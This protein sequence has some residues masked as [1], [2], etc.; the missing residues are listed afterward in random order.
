MILKIKKMLFKVLSPYLYYYYKAKIRFNKFSVSVMSVDDTI[1]KMKEGYSIVRFGDGEFLIIAG[2]DRKN[3]QDYSFELASGIA[4]AVKAIN[5][6]KYLVCLPETLSTIDN[7]V[8]KSKIR[9]ITHIGKNLKTYKKICNDDVVYGNAFVSRPYMI[10]KNKEKSRQW[11][12]EILSLFENK[13]FVLIEGQY[14]RL[15]VGNDLFSKAKSI[16][17]ILCPSKNAYE[18]YTEILEIAKK[19]PKNKIVLVSIGPAA[20][21]LVYDLY[22]EGFIVWDIGHIDSEYEWFLNQSYTKTTIANKHTAEGSNDGKDIGE[23]N[24]VEYLNS[25]IAEIY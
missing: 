23:C 9:W 2:C 6:P 8:K 25:I 3:Y 22:K 17:R 14:S 10:Y 18:K 19:L 1:T 15:G 7:C 13:E 16:E 11:F 24:D 21:P 12:S 5:E 20:K 4:N